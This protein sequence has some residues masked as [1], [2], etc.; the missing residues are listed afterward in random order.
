MRRFL[1]NLGSPSAGEVE[2]AAIA[3]YE[4]SDGLAGWQMIDSIDVAD[5]EDDPSGKQ[6]WDCY[7]ADPDRYAKL[8]S[9]S[10]S[11]VERHDGIV[12]PP[13]PADPLTAT[14]YCYTIDASM[15][16]KAGVQF[17]ARPKT[18]RATV[19]QRLIIDKGSVTTDGA[20]YAA[21]TIPADAGVL[22]LVLGSISVEV[23]TAGRAGQVINL[24]DLL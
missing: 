3:L 15:G 1:F 8:V 24:K 10:A 20:G 18:G 21:L 14:I 22:R 5:L 7:P 6:R 16:I 19:G 2:I 23:D 4:S 13:L 9:V 17:S 12:L 11:G